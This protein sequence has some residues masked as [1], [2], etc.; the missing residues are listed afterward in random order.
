MKDLTDGSIA[1]NILQMAAPIA[2]GMFFQTFIAS[3]TL[4]A[5]FSLWLVRG[6]FRRRL[7]LPAASH[8]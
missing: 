7:V 4:Q 1:K 8:I 5:C 2:A 6:E 3:V